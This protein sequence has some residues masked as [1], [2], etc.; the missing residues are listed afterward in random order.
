MLYLVGGSG[1]AERV[2]VSDLFVRRLAGYGLQVDYVIFSREPA[3][4]W[5]KT[6]WRGATAY[7][8]GRSRRGGI[9][10]AAINKLIELAADLRTCWLAMTGPYDVVQIRDKFVVGVLCVW[11]A[12][13]RRIRFAYWL[14]YPY[15]ENRIVNAQTGQSLLPWLTLIASKMSAWLLYKVILPGADHVFVQSAQMQRD[16]ASQGIPS[17]KMTAVRMAVDESLLEKRA[18]VVANT[19]L[20]LGHAAEVS[21]A[22]RSHRSPAACQERAPGCK[23]NLR[24]RRRGFERP[25]VARGSRRATGSARCGR[26]HWHVAMNDAHDRV[27][28]AAVCVSPFYPTPILQSTSPTKLYEYLA[29]GRPVVVNHHPEQSAVIAESGAGVCVEWSARAFA[30]GIAML[31]SDP[32]GAEIMG[33]RGR[34]YARSHCVYS[35]VARDVAAEYGRLLRLPDSGAGTE[36]V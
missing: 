9:V 8:V 22:R 24:R 30:D 3:P 21:A 34:A 17:A 26:V 29:L 27:A 12:R 33:A 36:T 13:L 20:Y 15:A 5:R 23:A 11:A 1:N 31:F 7:R 6:Q 32:A 35:V 28:S 25:A 19:V 18:P 16:E 2:D 4:A 10:G 14:S